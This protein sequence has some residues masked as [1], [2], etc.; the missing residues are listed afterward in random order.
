[1]NK[2]IDWWRTRHAYPKRKLAHTLL[3]SQEEGIKLQT[4]WPVCDVCHKP[5]ETFEW[6]CDGLSCVM[7]VV[8]HGERETMHIGLDRILD[9]IDSA[10]PGGRAFVRRQMAEQRKLK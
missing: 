9:L 1:M 8:C 2:T 3:L 5:V 4:L 6:V 7:T 10:A